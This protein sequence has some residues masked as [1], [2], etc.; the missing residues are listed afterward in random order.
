MVFAE[1]GLKDL[2]RR[3]V[4][5]PYRG[6]LGQLPAGAELRANRRLGALAWRLSGAKRAQILAA[7]R[8]ALPERADHEAIA[9]QAFATHFADQYISW[10]FARILA[11]EHAA[12]LRLEGRA[13]LDAAL[14]LGRGV[15]LLHPHMGPAQLP[16]VV[17]AALGYR[18]NQIGGGGVAAPLSAEGE[19]V[20]GVRRQ[21]EQALPAPI[22]DG[23]AFLRPALRALGRGEVVLCAADGTGGGR[24]LGRREVRA[25]LGLRYR[26]PVGA[27]Y[28]ALRSGAPLLPL[29]TFRNPGPGP[30]YVS[31]LRPPL[32]LERERPLEEALALGADRVAWQLDR[33]LR[34]HPGDWHFWDELRE[35][36]FL[37]G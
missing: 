14:A 9:R 11:G 2:Y 26:V 24:E 7:L 27:V 16:L 18:V 17:L 37:E 19:R 22:L 5:G 36:A 8:R 31:E 10:S 28:L 32:A 34:D 25:V 23:G 35:G 3:V 4:W 33:W 20:A 13:H 29:V 21:L 12:Y 30:D 6:L 1:S 15:V